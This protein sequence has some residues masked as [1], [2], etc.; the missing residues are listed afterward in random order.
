MNLTLR[1]TRFAATVTNV[2][3]VPFAAPPF[4]VAALHGGFSPAGALTPVRIFLQI[5][6]D[7]F[8]NKK[9]PFTDELHL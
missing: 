9:S 2:V 1:L 8:K 6:G 3:L 7:L 4:A 5:F